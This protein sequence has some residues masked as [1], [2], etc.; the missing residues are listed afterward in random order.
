MTTVPQP[1]S[2]YLFKADTHVKT[3]W[4]RGVLIL[5]ILFSGCAGSM[6]EEDDQPVILRG[7][8]VIDLEPSDETPDRKIEPP[9]PSNEGPNPEPVDDDDTPTEEEPDNCDLLKPPEV[10]PVEAA[11]TQAKRL[12]GQLVQLT[13]ASISL[14]E[15]SCSPDNCEQEPCC[16]LCRT[17]LWVDNILLVASSCTEA[18]TV[19]CVQQDCAPSVCTPPVV[20][21]PRT[22]EGVLIDGDPI[23]LELLRILN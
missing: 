23:R 5:S 1:T 15:Q 7:R 11:V 8:G 14:G 9:P 18:V 19:E 17:P 6:N 10:L 16:P 20:G 2:E 21:P 4:I 22:Y 12:N 13:N 3:F